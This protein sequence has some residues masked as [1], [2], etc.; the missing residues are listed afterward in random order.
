MQQGERNEHSFQNVLHA[1]AFFLSLKICLQQLH[2]PPLNGRE[3]E[4][5]R[6][7]QKWPKPWKEK[8]SRP[9]PHDRPAAVTATTTTLS[10]KKTHLHQLHVPCL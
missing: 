10:K 9:L 8:E 7:R 5:P 4:W 2:A 3:E 1:L 6:E